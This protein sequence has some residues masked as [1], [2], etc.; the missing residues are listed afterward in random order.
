MADETDDPSELSL[1]R[2]GNRPAALPVR[3][4]GPRVAR[5][6]SRLYR[7]AEPSLR[8]ALLACL[9]RPLGPLGLVAIA[10]G[11]FAGFLHRSGST[12]AMV[13][14]DVERFSREQVIELAN[15]VEQ[16]SPEALHEFAERVA[17]NAFGVAAFSATAAML[18]MRILRSDAPASSA[19][20][21]M[22]RTRRQ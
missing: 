7:T 21:A 9:V 20:V 8:V 15:F 12:S 1:L 10:S 14:M 5:L 13:A 19:R 18:L 17:E 2:Q 3:P 11:A 4:H 6:V 22:P 16:V